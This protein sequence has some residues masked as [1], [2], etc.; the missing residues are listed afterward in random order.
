M[1]KSYFQV[2]AM[3]PS[4]E[5]VLRISRTQTA[6]V[7]GGSVCSVLP[8][9]L[10]VGLPRRLAPVQTNT[11]NLLASILTPPLCP[12]PLSSRYRISVLLNGM[13]GLLSIIRM[14]K[15]FYH[16]FFFFFFRSFQGS[17]KFKH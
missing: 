4:E 7:L 8:P 15:P 16:L 9:D 11:V 5:P 12:S 17:S 14:L 3:E 1:W 13:A 2:V 10:L 6:L